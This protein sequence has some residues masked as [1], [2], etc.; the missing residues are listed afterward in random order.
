MR[1]DLKAAVKL[2]RKAGWAV[3]PPSS[4]DVHVAEVKIK[5]GRIQPDHLTPAQVHASFRLCGFEGEAIRYPLTT[6]AYNWVCAFNG[7]NPGETPWTWRY[8][9]N[10]WMQSYLDRRAESEGFTD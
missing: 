8:A 7:A 3:E 10:P 1:D 4:E 2:L 5:V 9:P 6:R